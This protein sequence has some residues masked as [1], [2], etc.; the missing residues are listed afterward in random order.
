MERSWH[1]SPHT[2][3]HPCRTDG[4]SRFT[5]GQLTQPDGPELS[6][7]VSH[8]VGHDPHTA[9]P[10]FAKGRCDAATQKPE[11]QHQTYYRSEAPSLNTSSD[12]S[13][14]PGTSVVAAAGTKVCKRPLLFCGS[15]WSP[16]RA[17]ACSSSFW[18][19]SRIL[20]SSA[21]TM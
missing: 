17:C 9:L 16:V 14:A 7:L 11:P 15:G 10:P 4:A 6:L 12:N 21:Y 20:S 1:A 19:S 5:W 13:R 3:S 8:R 2:M 18:F